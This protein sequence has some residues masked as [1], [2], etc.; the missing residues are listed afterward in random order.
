MH[1]CI[2]W[3]CQNVYVSLNHIFSQ[4]VTVSAHFPIDNIHNQIVDQFVISLLEFFVHIC[5]DHFE[6]LEV[7]L[8]LG[9]IAASVENSVDDRTQG[10]VQ[11]CVDQLHADVEFGHVGDDPLHFVHFLGVIFV[12]AL[13][14]HG[15]QLEDE[16]QF[17][18]F[19]VGHRR[20]NAQDVDETTPCQ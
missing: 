17:V 19:L 16:F 13:D 5:D 14:L 9:L 11:L 18:F 6:L 2:Y 8:R 7:L 10:V 3:T 20:Q 12:Q 1:E 4:R 15:E